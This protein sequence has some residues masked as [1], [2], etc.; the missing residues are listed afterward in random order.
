M[1]EVLKDGELPELNDEWQRILMRQMGM[2]AY[3]INE[4]PPSLDTHERAKRCAFVPPSTIP[5]TSLDEIVA[6]APG[7]ARTPRCSRSMGSGSHREQPE[8]ECIKSLCTLPS[9]PEPGKSLEERIADS[10]IRYETVPT[11]TV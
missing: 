3:L 5:P 7:S 1:S 10:T 11:H 9:K 6:R 8:G 2:S 4:E